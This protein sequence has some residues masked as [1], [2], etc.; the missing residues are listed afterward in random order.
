MKPSVRLLPRS[1]VGRVFALYAFALLCFVSAC[2]ALFFRYQLAVEMGNT[3][4]RA[5]SMV[6]VVGPAIADS[7]VIGDYDTIRRTLGRAVHQSDFASASYLDVNGGKISVDNNERPV[8]VPPAWLQAFIGARLYD[9]NLPISVGGRDYGV[10]RMKFAADRIAGE[11]WSQALYA[12]G[13]AIGGLAG[14][15]LLLHAP[16]KYWLDD[17]GRMGSFEEHL[18]TGTA[19]P[20]VMFGENA[21]IEFKQTFDV[22]NR[23]AASMQAQ[24]EQAAATLGAIGDGVITF[25]AEGRVILANPAACRM[26]ACGSEEQ[27]LGHDVRTT[28]PELFDGGRSFTAWASRRVHIHPSDGRRLV[29]DSTLSPIAGPA[30]E[31][32]DHVLALRNVTAQ[33]ALDE[34]LR[35]ERGVREKA[36]TALRDLLEGLMHGK[37]MPTVPGPTD[38]LAAVSHLIKGLVLQ[39]QARGEQLNAIFALSPDGFVSFDEQ[40]S[41]N[42]VSPAFTRLTGLAEP[43]VMGL[44][45]SAFGQLLAPQCASG[46]ALLLDLESLRRREGEDRPAHRRDLVE[47]SRPAKRV[48]EVALR[49]SRSAGISQVLHLRDVTHETEVEQIKS[50]FLSTAA[51]E[52]RTPMASIFGFSELMMTRKMT[53]ERQQ[54]VLATIHRQT[55]LMISIV[56]ELLDLARIEARRGK[57]FSLVDLDLRTLT[58]EVVHDF[59]PPNERAAPDMLLPQAPVPVRVDRSKM[60]Q[61]LGNVLSNAYKYSPEGGAVQVRVVLREGASGPQ[62]GIEVQDRGIGMTPEQLARVCERFYRADTSGNIPGTG[63]GMSIV[64]EIVE[65][66]GGSLALASEPGRGTTATLWLP[67]AA[68]APAGEAAPGTTQQAGLDTEPEPEPAP[69]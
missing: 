57:D 13:L 2:L 65:L 56:N 42:Y 21:P 64:K 4:Q 32:Q 62:A 26:L 54:E 31:P 55:E 36:M 58:R 66:L 40:R 68:L 18:R 63:L 16:L 67:S 30:G 3:Q 46:A 9:S 7:A 17:L 12:L 5:E 11:L 61:A 38:D 37:A 22:L 51:H 60:A 27:L 39:L 49:Q 44:G 24:R 47:L 34:R 6:E 25:D 53:P 1:L 15:L 14:G 50:E 33:H 43:V 41:V 20:A 35:N 19:Q 8:A 23:A 28:V 69:T 48:L 10:L 29:V 45:E 59:K 52:L